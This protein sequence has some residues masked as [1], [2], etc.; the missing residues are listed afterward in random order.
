[1]I[2]PIVRSKFSTKKN[3]QLNSEMHHFIKKFIY[4]LTVS[5]ATTDEA[6]IKLISQND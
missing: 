4:F 5:D 1:M 2:E 6:Y 3:V